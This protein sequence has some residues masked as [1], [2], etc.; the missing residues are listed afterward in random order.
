MFRSCLLG[1]VPGAV[2]ALLDAT[3]PTALMLRREHDTRPAD[4][5]GAAAEPRG[6]GVGARRDAPLGDGD[7]RG[8]GDHR[9]LRLLPRLARD[10]LPGLLGLW[11][12]GEP[13]DAITLAN[14][15]EERGE[16]EQVGGS[17]RVAELA[18]LV[19]ATANVEHYA[20]I[21]KETAT[22]RGLIQAGQEIARLGR[23]RIGRDGGARRPR[24]AD[25]L[26]PVPAADPRR[27]RPHRPAAHRELRADHEALRG[28]RGRHRH[29]V[30]LP[31]PRPPHVRVPAGQP[32]DPRRA[33]LDGEVGARAL[34]RREPRRALPDAGRAL[35]ARDVEGRGHAAPDVQ[36]GEGRVQ[37]RSLREAHPGGL[38]AADGRL[39]QADEGAD[40][41]RRHRLDHDDGAPVEGAT[42]QGARARR[43]A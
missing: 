28:G 27:L 26:R 13:V 33:P 40:L 34:H 20:R 32:R 25:R 2:A 35:H 19:S 12:K 37:P 8:D 31:R 16:L 18:A 22:L 6:G 9:R 24:R 30:R 5:R 11:A 29:A 43:S 21:V 39:R 23:E 10:D 17:A 14:E 38:A 7:R 1:A 41:R 36:R 3:V 42:A 4:G 15:L